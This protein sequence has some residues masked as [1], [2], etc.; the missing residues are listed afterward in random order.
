MYI[1]ECYINVIE[2]SFNVWSVC[3]LM[4]VIPLWAFV[5]YTE[6]L[7]FPMTDTK[8][9]ESDGSEEKV[10]LTLIRIWGLGREGT[11]NPY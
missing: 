2:V 8:S 5:G 10:P 11:V 1:A 6:T 9:L 3:I 4:C 7:L